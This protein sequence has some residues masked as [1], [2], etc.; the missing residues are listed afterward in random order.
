MFVSYVVWPLKYLA[1]IVVIS[2]DVV[3]VQVHSKNSVPAC[4]P[5]C[6]C[7]RQYLELGPTQRL[8]SP[9]ADAAAPKRTC[10]RP[11]R[12][13][14]QA[15]YESK[16]GTVPPRFTLFHPR[17]TSS[18][19]QH[20]TPPCHAHRKRRPPPYPATILLK[21]NIVLPSPGIRS[22]CAKW[23]LS[24]GKTTALRRKSTTTTLSTRMMVRDFPLCLLPPFPSPYH[25]SF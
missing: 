22:D 20:H 4:Q 14:K 1:Q 10:A 23:R 19:Y 9:G 11:I 15:G 17:N 13:A 24:T 21:I 6:R 7:L 25:L 8:W 2:V 16:R 5:K 3:E 18:L 12:F